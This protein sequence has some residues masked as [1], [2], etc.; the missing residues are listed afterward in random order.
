MNPVKQLHDF[1]QSPWMDY[2]H[3]KSLE[4]GELRRQI[5]DDGI[6]GVT[7]NPSIFEQA[8]GRGS[9]YDDALRELVLDQPRA[10]VMTLYE[11]L[12]VEDIRT[13]ADQL[14]PVFDD[15]GG[16]DGYVSLEVSPYRA[17]DTEGTIAEAKRLFAKVDRPNVMIKVPATPEGVP[18]IEELT[19]SGVNVNVTLMFSLDH[20]EA[21]AEAYVRGLERIDD[22]ETLKRVASVAS[23]FV[24]RVDGK[25]D[26]ELEAAGSDEA[27]ALRGKIAVANAK[28]AYRRFREIFHGERFAELEDRGAR[29]QRVLYGSTSTKNPEYSDVLYVEEL[30]GPETVNT[31]PPK[32]IDA[33]RDHGEPADRLSRDWDEAARRLQALEHVGIDLDRITEQ[34]QR[35]GVVSFAEDFDSLLAT[36]ERQRRRFLAQDARGGQKIYLGRWIG[37]V[38]DRLRQWQNA[39]FHERLWAHDR[40]LWNRPEADEILNRLGWLHLP[41]TM[42]DELD[43]IFGVAE[44]VADEG[45]EHIVV[46][47]MGGSSL[48]PEVFARTFGP[49]EGSPRLEVLDSTHP[50]AVTELAERLDVETTLF[51][52]SS[53]SGTTVETLSFFHTFWELVSG[54][55]RTPGRHFV[56]V[57]DPGTPLEDLARE[58]DFRH[59]FLAPPEVGGRY[60][61]LCH[62]GL[63]PAALAGYDADGLLDR[64]LGLAEAGRQD[65]ETVNEALR[66]GAALGELAKAGRDKVTFLTSSSLGAFPDWLEQLLAESTGKEGTGLVPVIGPAPGGDADGDG[67]R[68]YVGLVLEDDEGSSAVAETLDLMAEAGHPTVGLTLRDLLDLGREMFRWELAVAAAGAAL[69]VHPFD[70]PDVQL[71]KELARKAIRGELGGADGDR[72]A[73]TDAESLGSAVAGWLDGLGGDAYVGIQAYLAPD[74][75]TSRKLESLRL[76]LAARTHRATTVGYGPRF[77]HS[78]GQLHK[79]GPGSARFLQLVDRPEHDRPVPEGD[80]TFGELISGQARGD[81]EALIQSGH[82]VLTVDL[83]SDPA[84]GLDALLHAVTTV[85]EDS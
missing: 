68:V 61:A 48:A 39:T 44:E 6:S 12:A 70:Q 13:A 34:L 7:S 73:A 25:V 66:L 45:F 46:L 36:V 8:I 21:V 17:Y 47:G 71:A 79:G 16:D 37:P 81:R 64:A 38:M 31:M 74:E 15:T 40:S 56:A 14:R 10:P 30:I 57:T 26:P 67:D 50:D 24:S 72:V 33:F 62:F 41:R 80:A 22:E 43:E 27:R 18:A 84:S 83:G 65:P 75:A 60:S 58:R 23:F 82:G 5:E 3:R 69:D 32:T 53:K 19:A 42:E 59:V 51:V 85:G 29:V 20:Y 35:E 49:R 55:T 63:V 11:E 76:R 1:G 4:E 2:I 54:T 9:T 77:L 78:T 52:V 28:L